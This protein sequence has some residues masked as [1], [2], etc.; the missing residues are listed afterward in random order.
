MLPNFSAF[1]P[2]FWVCG[3]ARSLSLPHKGDWGRQRMREINI[4]AL[5][6]KKGGKSFLL[7]RG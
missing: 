1:N 6:L 7:K 4:S 3:L 2:F 5:P